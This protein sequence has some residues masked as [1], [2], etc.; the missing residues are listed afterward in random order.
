MTKITVFIN[1][2]VVFIQRMQI[3]KERPQR[4]TLLFT[5]DF[6]N[7]RNF[8]NQGQKNY[9]KEWRWLTKVNTIPFLHCLTNV[10]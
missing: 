8:K 3:N 10:G 6:G 7:L 4:V 5:M 2:I 1:P 9:F